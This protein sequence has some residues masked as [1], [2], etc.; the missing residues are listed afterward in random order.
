MRDDVRILG[1][2]MRDESVPATLTIID[3]DIVVNSPMEL[4]ENAKDRLVKRFA[5][6]LL[7]QGLELHDWKEKD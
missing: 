1:V 5:E 6:R 4:D 3:D 2:V 7:Q